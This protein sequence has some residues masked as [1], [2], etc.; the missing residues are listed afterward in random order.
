[1]ILI[2]VA[3]M[4]AASV[5]AV[6]DVEK[7]LDQFHA[8]AAKADTDG[9]FG[10]FAPEG[11]FLGTDATERWTV[12]EFK[13][14]AGPHFSKGQGWTYTAKTRHVDFTPDGGVAWF[15]ELLDNDKLGTCRGSGVL[16]KI[17][18]AWKISQYNLSIPIPNERAKKVVEQIRVKK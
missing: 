13:R 2:T 1:M 10:L 12:E 17:G 4:V 6:K 11:V 9:Y 15:D 14:Y 16:R 7:V 3:L 18:G 8:A 5:A